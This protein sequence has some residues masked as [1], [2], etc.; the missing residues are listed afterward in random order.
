VRLTARVRAN[1]SAVILVLLV[2]LL[3]GASLVWNARTV[4]TDDHKWCAAMTLLTAHPV[5][6]PAD[7]AAN[8]S[9]EQTYRF[10]ETFVTLQHSLGC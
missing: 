4:S 5:P 6:K 1:R 8:P 7:P 2:A 10:Y 9:R 3:S